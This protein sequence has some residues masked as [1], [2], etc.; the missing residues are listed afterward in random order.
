MDS[1]GFSDPYV[2]LHLLPGNAMATKLKSRTM[3]KTFNPEWSEE[4][5]YYGV[6]EADKQKKTLRITVLDRDRIDLDF[7]GE[8]QIA[9]RKLPVNTPEKFNLYLEHAIPVRFLSR[10]ISALCG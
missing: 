9:L 6:T 5:H 3:E 2:K 10:I 4:L 8:T 7:L 1:N